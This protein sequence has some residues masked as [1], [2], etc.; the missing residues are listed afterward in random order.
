[1]AEKWSDLVEPRSFTYLDQSTY[2]L[3]MGRL[4]IG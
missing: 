4:P 1:M 2:E 3:G